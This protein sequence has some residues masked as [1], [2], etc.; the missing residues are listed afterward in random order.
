[1]NKFTS[2][3]AQSATSIREERA[4]ILAED[5][6]EASREVLRVVTRELTELNRKKRSLSDM[7]PKSE[8]S[9]LVTD[10]AFN[11]AKWA[12]DMQSLSVA[13]ANKEVEVKI[14]QKNIDEWFSPVTDAA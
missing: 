2:N 8:L 12:A 11:S 3:L 10:E 6:E 4:S 5:A 9:L 7:Y 14:A 1:M 13:I